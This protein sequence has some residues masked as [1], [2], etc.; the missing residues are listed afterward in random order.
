MKGLFF[1]SLRTRLV[2][3]VLLAIVPTLLVM[4][5]AGLEQRSI[6]CHTVSVLK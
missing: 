5:H 4:F 2:L 6:G 3:M 1:A